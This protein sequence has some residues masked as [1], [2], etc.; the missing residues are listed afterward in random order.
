MF[1]AEYRE[2]RRRQKE[3]R[4]GAFEQWKTFPRIFPY[5]R[6][7]RKLVAL[8]FFFT[9][10]TATTGL[11]EPWPLAMVIDSVIGTNAPPSILRNWFGAS[12]DP[13]RLLVFIVGLG[14]L[15][16]VLSHGLRVINDYVNA[17]IEQNMVLNLR[18]DLFGHVQR[19]SL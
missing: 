17:K 5:L 1:F 12:P 4:V 10:L 14:F 15:I 19:L 18:S 11:A 8:S 16:V 13:Y 3:S 7:Y 6:P 9:V 2:H